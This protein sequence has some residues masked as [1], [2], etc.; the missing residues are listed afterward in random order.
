VVGKNQNVLRL[1]LLTGQQE[2]VS[3]VYFGDVEKF[4][5][6]YAA[7]FGEAEVEAAFRGQENQILMSIVYYPEINSY[8]GIDTIQ[9]TIRNYQ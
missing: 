9:L 1:S 7:K 8:Q 2:S 5:A 6:Y 3:A 4:K